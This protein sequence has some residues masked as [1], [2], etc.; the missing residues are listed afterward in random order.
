M[1]LSQPIHGLLGGFYDNKSFGHDAHPSDLAGL[2]LACIPLRRHY[3]LA[4]YRR[5]M[6]RTLAGNSR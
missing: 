2:Y 1:Q 5:S 3:K 4:D 6:L